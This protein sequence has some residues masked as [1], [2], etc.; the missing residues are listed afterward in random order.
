MDSPDQPVWS[1]LEDAKEKF[2]YADAQ[3]LELDTLTSVLRAPATTLRQ[4]QDVSRV[5]LAWLVFA[6]QV[7]TSINEAWRAAGSPARFASW[8]RSL[9]SDPT[10]AFFRQAR[11]AG[12]K[13]AAEIVVAH[14]IVDER[15][16]PLAYW[17][18]ASGPHQGEPIVARCQLYTDWLH[19]SM[20]AP[21]AERLFEW[22]L[23]ERLRSS[24]P[25]KL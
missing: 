5:Y 25:V 17:S 18:F 19:Y 23:A 20:W 14:S 8:W 7:G 10:H 1:R 16:S 2:A 11:N 24:A 6:R 21:A 9:E 13:G 15:I 3:L 4:R 12:L 22:T